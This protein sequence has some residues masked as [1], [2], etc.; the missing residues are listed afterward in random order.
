MKRYIFIVVAVAL[1]TVSCSK[2]YDTN[3]NANEGTAISLG[4]WASGLTRARGAGASAFANGDTL[5]VFGAKKND[6]PAA[7]DTVFN[8]VS[9]G[10]ADNG[11]TWTYSPIRFWDRGYDRYDFFAIS[12][13]EDVALSDLLASHDAALGTMTSKPIA[14][15][16][17]DNDILIADSTHVLKA[18]YGAPVN[19]VFRHI[20]AMFDLKVRKGAGIG[21]NGTL[22]IT[23]VSIENIDSLGTFAVSGYAASTDTAI[24]AWSPSQVG[25]YTNLSGIIPVS[26]LP[27][28]VATDA[29]STLID[30]LIVM[31]QTF[32]D[33]GDIQQLKI[34][35]TITTGTGANE[36][37]DTFTD[38]VYDLRLFDKSDYPTDD[39]AGTDGN[40][41]NDGTLVSG[42]AAGVHYIYIITIDAE[43][44]EFTAEIE[45]WGNENGYYYILN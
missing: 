29:T 27:T 8:G 42:W 41:Y 37:V 36:Q 11:V 43:G 39:D 34:S 38:K 20:N 6:A 14:L 45:P 15:A 25:H 21:D 13:S 40:Q 33:A 22:A 1:A 35:Y 32:R 24:V 17:N 2:T 16:G 28:D 12:P 3:R 18:A 4:S 19:L 26:T 30:S 7:C 10:T 9:V 23:A 31:P 5:Y 44:I